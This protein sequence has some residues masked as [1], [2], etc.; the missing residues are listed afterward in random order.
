MGAWSLLGKG[1]LCGQGGSW[2]YRV[3]RRVCSVGAP[4]VPY[5]GLLPLRGVLVYLRYLVA[6]A[7]MSPLSLQGMLTYL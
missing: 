3:L 2:S 7:R 1:W 4:V 6:V 5:M